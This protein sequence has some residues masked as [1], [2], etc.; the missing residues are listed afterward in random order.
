MFRPYWRR[1]P[2]QARACACALL[3]TLPVVLP[4]MAL[5]VS[6]RMVVGEYRDQYRETW[7]ILTK[8]TQNEDS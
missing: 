8:G 3:I 2:V 5:C 1:H 4:I 7:R 6:W